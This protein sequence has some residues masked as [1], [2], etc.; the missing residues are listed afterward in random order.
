MPK[1][2]LFGATKMP[3]A[4]DDDVRRP[5]P[6]VGRSSPAMERSVVV[7]RGASPEG[8][9]SMNMPSGTSNETFCT[10]LTAPP[11]RWRIR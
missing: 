11:P 7:F 6:A 4:D 3:F 8:P 10:A 1:L 2:R 5:S 9:S